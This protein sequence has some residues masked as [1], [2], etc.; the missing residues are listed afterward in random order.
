MSKEVKIQI[1]IANANKPKRSFSRRTSGH[2]ISLIVEKSQERAF[3]RKRHG[4][5][6]RSYAT[7]KAV[8]EYSQKRLRAAIVLQQ[9][10]Q[11]KDANHVEFHSRFNTAD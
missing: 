5:N 2:G 11:A 1:G 8:R 3:Q 4:D 7:P 9:V 10:R 6:K